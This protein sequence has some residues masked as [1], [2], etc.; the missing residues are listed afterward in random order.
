MFSKSPSL[1][2]NKMQRFVMILTVLMIALCLMITN[3]EAGRDRPR[4]E[5]P[6]YIPN[7]SY[8]MRRDR[9][10]RIMCKQ[11]FQLQGPKTIECIRGKWD[12]ERP[13]CAST[14]VSEKLSE[15]YCFVK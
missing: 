6:D 11:G 3:I 14:Y 12:G 2:S 4:C 7:G 15:F 8:R 5:K 10:M 1:S 13:V 9:V